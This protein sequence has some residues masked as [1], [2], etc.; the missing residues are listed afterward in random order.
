MADSRLVRWWPIAAL[1]LA[2]AGLV[3]WRALAGA[4]SL[5]PAATSTASASGAKPGAAHGDAV[6]ASSAHATPVSPAERSR[7]RAEAG[8]V[9]SDRCAP[10]HAEEHA[11]W[12]GSQHARA[13]QHASAATV[14]GNFEGAR[15]RYAGQVHRFEHQDGKYWVTTDGPDGQLHRYEVLYTFGVEP[16]QQYLV[17]GPGGRL[18][19]LPFAWDS[20]PQARGGQRWYHLHERDSVRAGDV[21]HWTAASQNW[22]HMCAE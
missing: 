1:T 11:A 13:M 22:N 15:L 3:V 18:Q 16:L 19:A 9:G 10:C 8:F 4:S 20:R 12:R 7:E 6:E 2:L 14:L 5:A 21:L 17:A